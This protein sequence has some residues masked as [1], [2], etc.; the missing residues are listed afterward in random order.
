M[1]RTKNILRISDGATSST[2]TTPQLEQAGGL[3]VR[4]AT[5]A[6]EARRIGGTESVDGIVCDAT[7]GSTQGLTLLS[8]FRAHDPHLPFVLVVDP[9]SE[10]TVNDALEAG[11]SDCVVTPVTDTDA[12]L[13]VRRL[14]NAVDAAAQRRAGDVT[15]RQPTGSLPA[16]E[17][18]YRSLMEDVLSVSYVGTLV[19]D[20][21]F[22][23]VWI[24]DSIETYFG[25]DRGI[26]G[27]NKRELI[28]TEIKRIF[29][30]PEAFAERV[31]ATYDDN[32]YIEQFECHV[33]P[34]EGREDR[35]LEH[36]SYP[37]SRGPYAGGRIEHYVDITA[38]KR[39][40]RELE[41]ERKLLDSLFETSPVGI[42]LL[43]SAG[44]IIRANSH[45]EVVLGRPQAAIVDRSYDDPAWEIHD[46]DGDPIPREE[47]PFARVRRTGEPVFDSEHGITLSDGAQRWLSINASPL[48]AA[49]GTVDRVICGIDDTTAIRNSGRALAEHN[50]RLAEFASVVSHDLRNPLNVLAGSIELAEE[51]GE[52]V[53]FERAAR[54]IERMNQL[55]S[56]LLSLAR[57]GEGI[58]RTEAVDV[59]RLVVECWQNLAVD[60]AILQVETEQIL[61]A[62]RSRLTQL[63]ENLFRNAVEHG[64]PTVT[65]TV[66]ELVDGFFVADDGPG[67]PERH[68]DRVFE[69]GYSST[70]GGTGLGLYIVD[71]IA[72]AHGWTVTLA[73][74]ESGTRIELTGVEQS[75][76]ESP[77]GDDRKRPSRK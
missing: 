77:F 54:A 34:G 64:G 17:A 55:I 47:L 2:L 37:I 42:V 38:R 8:E 45:A 69:R 25:V 21:A 70:P 10:S 14:L 74:T 29:E 26:I 68:R 49:D 65:I 12:T 36:W 56:D 5:T 23:V 3:A 15:D 48:L 39:R 53:H 16:S 60:E 72:E 44:R 52:T 4:T 50:E 46:E 58:D 40:E 19:L 59:G 22:R 57:A 51:T 28:D 13:V 6:S 9:D 18:N 41:A 71:R 32:S 76:S 62:D 43:D 31:G 66:G 35:W 75:A 20:A 30:E 7:V 33:L 1:G 73:D 67:I 11:V 61:A 63:F 24:N 27:T